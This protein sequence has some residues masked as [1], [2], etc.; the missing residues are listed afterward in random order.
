MV[1]TG[2][3]STLDGIRFL[4]LA[5]LHGISIG[6]DRRWFGIH[7][8]AV[9]T[10][11]ALVAPSGLL[12]GDSAQP[13][14]QKA[15]WSGAAVLAVCLTSLWHELG[16]AAA[17]RLA[18]LRVRA[19]VV[20][21]YGGLTIRAS[22]DLATANVFTALSGPLANGLLGALALAC[23]GNAPLAP[24]LFQFAAVQFLTAAI[25]MLP[26][27]TLDGARALRALLFI[28]TAQQGRRTLNTAA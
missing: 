10:L 9:C 7:G 20:G 23:A 27:G 5:Q 24:C 3:V 16:H 21:P 26:F 13:L 1:G 17:G 11:I 6:L 28:K 25:N 15:C 14:W 8:L 12:S 2:P 18:G 22:S 19:V 4:R